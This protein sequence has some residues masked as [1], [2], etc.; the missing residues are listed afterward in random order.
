MKKQMVPLLMTILF[1][2][3]CYRPC[4][5]GLY[6]SADKESYFH[7]I[8]ECALTGIPDLVVGYYEM[9][10]DPRWDLGPE[11]K[12]DVDHFIQCVKLSLHRVPLMKKIEELMRVVSVDMQG[13][14]FFFWG[15]R[16]YNLYSCY[17]P[18]ENMGIY[19]ELRCLDTDILKQFMML[20]NMAQELPPTPPSELLTPNITAHYSL[21]CDVGV[22]AKWV[23][24][25]KYT[26]V[27]IQ[28]HMDEIDEIIAM[29]KKIID[30]YPMSRN[31][32]K[33]VRFYPCSS[34]KIQIKTL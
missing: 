33:Y 19:I 12:R 25:P 11:T 27:V 32:F 26:Q 4:K 18:C 24:F 28:N 13:T 22:E 8:E 30:E 34:E 31:D 7:S 29:L 9:Y 2:A 23:D 14:I 1:M 3:S 21:M 6:T 16:D 10:R 20:K 17:V 5:S 15:D